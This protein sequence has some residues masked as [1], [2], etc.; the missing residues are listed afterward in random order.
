[1][2]YDEIIKNAQANWDLDKLHEDSLQA[3]RVFNPVDDNVVITEKE[4]YY[5]CALLCN[6]SPKKI[7]DFFYAK[8]N[9]CMTNARY[10]TVRDELT[11]IY[12]YA[13]EIIFRKTGESVKITSQTFYLWM[14]DLGFKNNYSPKSKI[15]K[16]K[17]RVIIDIDELPEEQFN[18]IL[19]I[20]RSIPG[21]SCIV[22][23]EER[24]SI[25]LKIE[26]SEAG[27]KYIQELFETGALAD[28]LEVPVLD[29]QQDAELEKTNLAVWF[30]DNYNFVEAVEKG[31]KTVA[32]ILT[33]KSS[34]LA[35]RSNQVERAKK[36]EFGNQKI[37]LIINIKKINDQKISLF[38][39]LYPVEEQ[40]YLPEN[41]RLIVFFDADESEEIP[42]NENR[43]GFQQEIFFSPGEEFSIQTVVGEDSVTE[44]FTI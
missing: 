3:K 42:V 44:N 4:N 11:R 21:N 7:A 19:S 43:E 35:F 28:L 24:G 39:G 9:L 38:L 22:V 34:Q 36:I 17:R 6:L 13:E 12:K 29:V 16:V 8:K 41:L 26:T 5:I 15:T 2:N 27:F 32:Q 40:I 20:F 18:F 1:M 10:V 30:E 33:N 14:K 31:W 23:E 37:G 25:I